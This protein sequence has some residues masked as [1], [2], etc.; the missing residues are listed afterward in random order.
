MSETNFTNFGERKYPGIS[1]TTVTSPK[2]FTLK[3]LDYLTSFRT[4]LV[5][6]LM[7]EV[8]VV[9]PKILYGL[10]VVFNLKRP[11]RNQLNK[12]LKKKLDLSGT[13]NFIQFSYRS[14]SV[15]KFPI[16]QEV[17]FCFIF[18]DTTEI[19]FSK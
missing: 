11:S 16:K 8:V 3:V 17:L 13:V 1:Q 2:V 6:T 7:D 19:V 18:R 9:T 10:V 5:A 4:H 14:A 15:T 12:Y